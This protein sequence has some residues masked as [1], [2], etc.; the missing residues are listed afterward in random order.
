M[1]LEEGNQPSCRA[2]PSTAPVATVFS[3]IAL[4]AAFNGEIDKGNIEKGRALML[5]FQGGGV[6][7]N[8][9]VLGQFIL[10]EG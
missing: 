3:M 7:N 5:D 6:V 2:C 8:A 9:A 10:G 1:I 4:T